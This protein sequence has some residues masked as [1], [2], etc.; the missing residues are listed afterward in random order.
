MA[1]HT[2]TNEINQL[3]AAGLTLDEIR[4]ASD[5]RIDEGWAET[6]DG[7]WKLDENGNHITRYFVWNK[8]DLNS[9]T[10]W[11]ESIKPKPANP[12]TARQI[13][14]IRALIARNEE[15]GY[16][17]VPSEPAK[18]EIFLAGLDKTQASQLI[19][20]LTGNY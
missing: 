16:I 11:S 2:I 8:R 20:S 1:Q 7:D 9:F 10:A 6:A 13:G 17:S 15:P 18:L 14:Y 5:T 19:D 3:L 4:T 12:A